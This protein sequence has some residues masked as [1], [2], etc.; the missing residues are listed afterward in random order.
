MR[1][2]CADVFNAWIEGGTERFVTEGLPR[3][4]ARALV[5]QMLGALEGAFVLSRALRSTEPVEL[6]G[7]ASVTAI[8]A[9][10]AEVAILVIAEALVGRSGGFGQRR[11]LH[12]L[13]D[14]PARRT[15]L[16]G[17]APDSTPT[18]ARC[19]ADTA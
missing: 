5:I 8:E 16:P 10:L 18:V 11:S 15:S 12:A 14:E 1:Q 6:A 7:E 2:A 19:S 17:G 4:Q 3:D 9:A 13:G